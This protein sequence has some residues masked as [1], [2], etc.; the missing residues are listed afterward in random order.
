MNMNDEKLFLPFTL[1]ISNTLSSMSSMLFSPEGDFYNNQ[2]DLNSFGATVVVGFSGKTKGRFLI[3]LETCVAIELAAKL[4]GESFNSIKDPMVI[5]TLSEVGNI[6]AGDAITAVNNEFSYGLRLVPPVVFMGDNMV[7]GL[8]NMESY[9]MN[10]KSEYGK[11]R[12]N[13]AFEK[14]LMK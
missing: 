8:Q 9:T 2:G 12:I 11:L 13:V 14:G 3:D 6:T 5:A 10:F 7:V 1:S 4:N